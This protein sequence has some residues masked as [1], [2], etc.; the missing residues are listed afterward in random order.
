M[1]VSSFPLFNVFPMQ[2]ST[3]LIEMARNQAY[4]HQTFKRHEQ[5]DELRSR[6]SKCSLSPSTPSIQNLLSAYQ[7]SFVVLNNLELPSSTPTLQ[8]RIIIHFLNDTRSKVFIN[9]DCPEVLRRSGFFGFLKDI[10]HKWFN[11]QV[12]YEVL[13]TLEQISFIAGDFETTH[14][15]YEL[16]RAITLEISKRDTFGDVSGESHIVEKSNNILGNVFASGFDH[17]KQRTL[18][19]GIIP[20][21]KY[22][23][24]AFLSGHS[25]ISSALYLLRN[26]V[27]D[28]NNWASPTSMM[29]EAL[30]VLVSEAQFPKMIK[31]ALSPSK[32]NQKNH[33]SANELGEIPE[34]KGKLSKIAVDALWTLYFVSG[35]GLLDNVEGAFDYLMLVLA[36]FINET[37]SGLPVSAMIALIGSLANISADLTTNKKHFTLEFL[38]RVEALVLRDE[39]VSEHVLK[40]T[41][42]LLSNAALVNWEVSQFIVSHGGLGAILEKCMR[43]SS[44]SVCQGELKNLLNTLAEGHNGEFQ[45]ELKFKFGFMIKMTMEQSF[46]RTFGEGMCMQNG[47]AQKYVDENIQ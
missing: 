22:L 39:F 16:L 44:F 24:F 36:D 46:P 34:P 11:F 7:S 30:V 13:V 9:S 33:W 19:E 23:S 43:S 27:K 38:R 32:I 15:V 40:E 18:S 42:V 14:Q 45:E 10:L 3:P 28:C 35:S 41:L 25:S 6:L 31:S 4:S 5:L 29:N 37:Q 26:L 17:L 2:R 1:A 47:R 12:V 21:K 20:L 8:N